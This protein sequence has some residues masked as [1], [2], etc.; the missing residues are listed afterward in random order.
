MKVVV[1]RDSCWGSTGMGAV[2]FPG[3]HGPPCSGRPILAVAVA[4]DKGQRRAGTGRRVAPD[5]K[6]HSAGPTAALQHASRTNSQGAPRGGRTQLEMRGVGFEQR[7]AGEAG[8]C[9]WSLHS[10]RIVVRQ[11]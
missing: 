1:L 4:E 2:K 7:P 5:A 3:P 11:G 10:W 6:G 9:S 8:L